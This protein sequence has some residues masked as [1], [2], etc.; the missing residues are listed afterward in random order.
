LYAQGYDNETGL[1][2]AWLETNETGV[3]ENKSIFYLNTFNNSLTIKNVTFNGNEN[4]TVWI[5]LPKN[6]NVLSAK[7]K[8]K[9]YPYPNASLRTDDD[10]EDWW[11]WYK[12]SGSAGELRYPE[13]AHDQNWN[14]FAQCTNLTYNWFDTVYCHI[15]ENYT[16]PSYAKGAQIT[17]KGACP[18]GCW[19]GPW[20]LYCWNWTK[21]MGYWNSTSNNSWMK[22]GTS[23]AWSSPGNITVNVTPESNW[24]CWGPQV[25]AKP[26]VYDNIG[27][28][29]LY[30]PNNGTYYEGMVT[31]FNRLNLDSDYEWQYSGYYSDTQTTADFSKEINDYLL[32]CVPD[33]SGYCNVS[34]IL[35]SNTAGRI[36]LSELNVTYLSGNYLKSYNGI[37]NQT[38]WSSFTWKNDSIPAVTTVGWRINY[39]D[40]DGNR[41]ATNV[42][43]FKVK[44]PTTCSLTGIT[45]HSYGSSD[46]A[47]CTCTGDGITHLYRNETLHDEWNNTPIVFGVGS[48]N[49]VCNMTEG[50]N[51]ATASK[52]IPQKIDKANPLLNLSLSPPSPINYEN[53]TTESCTDINPEADSKL[54]RNGVEVIP[55]S[56]I[57]AAGTYNY[58]CNI[59][60]TENYTSDSDPSTYIVDKKNANVQVYPATQT[61]VYGNSVSQYCTDESNLLDCKLYRDEILIANNTNE[62]LGIG[63]Y[64]YLANISDTINYTSYQT[65]SILTVVNCTSDVDCNDLNQCTDDVCINPGTINSYCYYPNKSNGTSC[66]DGLFCTVSDQ[67]SSGV[68]VGTTRDCSDGNE[69]TN[70]TCNEDLDQCQHSNKLEG[71]LCGLARDCPSDACVGPKAYFYPDDGHDTCNGQGVC[72][73]YS[74]ALQNSY[75]TDNNTLDG[76]NSLECG[77]YCDQKE[78]CSNECDGNKW[79]STYN[80]TDSCSC[81]ASDPICS[82]GKCGAECDDPEDCASRVCKTDCT[83]EIVT[84]TT[85]TTTTSTSTTTST[86]TSTS[87]T[88]TTIPETTPPVVTIIY[89]WNRTFYKN[90]LDLNFTVNEPTSWIG[91]S[92]DN[93]PNMTITGNTTMTG[94]SNSSHNVIVYAKDLAGNTGSNA[95]YFTVTTIGDVN[96]D[97]KVDVK[98]TVLVIKYFGSYPGHPTKPW[99][100]NADINFDNK[101]DVKDMV[102][103]NKYFGTYCA[104]I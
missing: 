49:W 19:M 2:Y 53:I 81:Q 59:S 16:T 1:R 85:T 48:Y 31:W 69:C 44:I 89:P 71:T 62:V 25:V 32:Y 67:C 45:N 80:C 43:T 15:V 11:G 56:L 51:Y 61:I 5:R 41:N 104:G 8:L 58:I 47:I 23:G 29:T 33:A 60:A 3:W 7:V 87:T 99:N 20:E 39:Q 10:T 4:K 74:C 12:V 83:C 35:H 22:I 37:P 82:K 73:E 40:E 6:S 100:P 72:V 38:V 21:N 34:L 96:G 98:D 18:F 28:D 17:V 13:R 76:I 46:T 65:T 54:Y 9:G 64:N 88:T 42:M 14:T 52:I 92:L 66:D 86:I 55:S 79:Y 24:D 75:C 90:S 94:L 50:A 30:F 102:L 27:D 68:C 70:D 103:V 95:T 26:V 77:A 78:D 84:T 91:Y 63:T 57:L 93:K 36:E 101:V 97:C